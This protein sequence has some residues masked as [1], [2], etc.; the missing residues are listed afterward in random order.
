MPKKAGNILTRK[1]GPF[2][3]YVWALG[4]GGL[5]VVYF[6]MVGR[7]SSGSSAPAPAGSA[8]NNPAA[9]SMPFV[10]S[11]VVT[12]LGPNTGAGTTPAVTSPSGTGGRSIEE[13]AP[14]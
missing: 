13:R 14:E 3:G 1:I 4:A 10:P 7:S 12:G 2:P 8:Q 6:F 9:S 5:A 11:V